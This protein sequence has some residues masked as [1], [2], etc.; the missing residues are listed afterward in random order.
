M[1]KFHFPITLNISC[2]P[3]LLLTVSKQNNNMEN[4]S[5]CEISGT[6]VQFQWNL[7]I[8]LIYRCGQHIYNR[9]MHFSHKLWQRRTK[10]GERKRA[11]DGA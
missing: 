5:I 7:R 3:L 4:V 10:Q 11:H 8:F 9:A 6:I 1:K 2:I